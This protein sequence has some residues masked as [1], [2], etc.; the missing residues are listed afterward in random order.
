MCRQVSFSMQ[1]LFDLSW[2]IFIHFQRQKLQLVE[3][4][5]WVLKDFGGFY[6][7]AFKIMKKWRRRFRDGIRLAKSRTISD[8]TI[9]SHRWIFKRHFH[10]F[11]HKTSLGLIGLCMTISNLSRNVFDVIWTSV[12]FQSIFLGCNQKKV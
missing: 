12:A 3:F 6:E 7:F 11:F 1:I 8:F 2:V 5:T 9:W 4:D 10:K